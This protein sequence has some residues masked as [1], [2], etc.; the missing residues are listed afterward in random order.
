MPGL[1][2]Q[3]WSHPRLEE[4]CRKST[5]GA[6]VAIAGMLPEVYGMH[7]NQEALKAS[8]FGSALQNT[9]SPSPWNFGEWPKSV[10]H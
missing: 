1:R 3:R 5:T 10:D 8:I 4:V 6:E 9:R 7:E 2:S